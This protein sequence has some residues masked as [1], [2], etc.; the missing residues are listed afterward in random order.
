MKKR[1]L[2]VGIVLLWFF[3]I[4]TTCVQ[5]AEKT[6]YLSIGQWIQ[7]NLT[8][9]QDFNLNWEFETYN[10][11]FQA[12]VRIDDPDGYYENLITAESGSGVYVAEKQ[13]DY[14]I[15]LLNC[16][17]G[18]G[19]IHFTYSEPL[20]AISGY[21]PLVIIGVIG[22]VMVGMRKKLKGYQVQK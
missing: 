22:M 8:L 15:T 18:G 2:L 16:G 14:I 7:I 3:L 1:T 11:S 17:L 21:L 4:P 13:G 6:Q 5:A 9:A 10:N 20:P 12:L 19:Y